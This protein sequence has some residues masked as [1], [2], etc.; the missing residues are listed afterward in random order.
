M[1]KLRV[2]VVDDELPIREW[3]KHLDWGSWQAEWVGD[4]DNGEVALDFCADNPPDVVVADITM[5]I[6]GGLELFHVLQDEFPDI[7]VILLTNHNDFEYA[8]QAIKLGAI[9]YLLKGGFSPVELGRAL[10]L[11]REQLTKDFSHKWNKRQQERIRLTEQFRRH[12]VNPEAMENIDFPLLRK[13]TS[14]HT[15]ALGLRLMG[16]PEDLYFADPIMQELLESMESA[17]QYRWFPASFGQYLL[18]SEDASSYMY[19][20]NKMQEFV[21]EMRNKIQSNVNSALGELFLFAYGAPIQSN[22][23]LFTFYEHGD[24]WRDAY[25]YEESLLFVGKPPKFS[26]A[27]GELVT[28]IKTAIQMYHGDAML[29]S[30]K[31]DVLVYAKDQHI[32]PQALIRE[33]V[34]KLMSTVTPKEYSTK[35]NEQVRNNLENVRTIRELHAE[36]VYLISG[37]QVKESRSEIISIKNYVVTNLDKP[38]SLSAIASEVGYNAQYLGKLFLEATGENF[39]A[40]VT[41]IRMEKAMELIWNTNKKIYLIAEEVGFTNYRYFSTLF[42]KHTGISPTEYKKG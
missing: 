40:Y 10:K 7:K 3:L 38:L 18:I 42:Q 34:A 20:F 27:D 26:D 13:D 9:D 6:M 41:R 35:W 8:R 37:M 4:A 39:K 29:K 15:M 16:E 28:R 22:Q 14:I 21:A 23:D 19:W 25:F 2:L 1:D 30:L 33:L 12:L 31:N 24:V 5:P 11:A 17:Y 36:L 32:Y